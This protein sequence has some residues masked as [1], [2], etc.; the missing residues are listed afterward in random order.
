[1]MTH[2]EHVKQLL[3]NIHTIVHDT[4]H[5]K[6][7]IVGNNALLELTESLRNEICHAYTET[8]DCEK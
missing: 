1:M 4:D 7:T 5:W 8:I 2:E 6:T 3:A